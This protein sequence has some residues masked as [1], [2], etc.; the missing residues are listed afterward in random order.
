MAY[1]NKIVVNGAEVNANQ[2]E[3]ILDKNG[4]ARFVE[5]NGVV[6]PSVNSTYCK[7]SLS[8]THLMLVSAFYVENGESISQ[9]KTLG[10]YSMPSWILAKIVTMTGASTGNISAKII[11]GMGASAFPVSDE[12]LST[13]L[14]KQSE[15][16]ILSNDIAYTNNSGETVYFR[17]QFD[18][19]ID[20]E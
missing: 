19:I 1:I 18:L 14:Q 5:G 11:Q 8:G 13:Y 2:L 4:N 9:Y 16:L 7:W 17:V 12:E 10:S 6:D 20:N 15:S 3:G